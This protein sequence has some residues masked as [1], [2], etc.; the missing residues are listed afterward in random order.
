VSFS[1]YAADTLD[2]RVGAVLTQTV[3][4]DT[5]LAAIHQHWH[6]TAPGHP[7]DLDP[8]SIADR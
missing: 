6:Q 3:S 7:E 8:D 4:K 1:A 5:L 2:R